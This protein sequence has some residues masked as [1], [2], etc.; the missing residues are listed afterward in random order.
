MKSIQGI[1]V[2]NPKNVWAQSRVSL[3]SNGHENDR[4]TGTGMAVLTFVKVYSE[5]APYCLKQRD[6]SLEFCDTMHK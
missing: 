5:K 6:I 3:W 1:L 4:V 2:S